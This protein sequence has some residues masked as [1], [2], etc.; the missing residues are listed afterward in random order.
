M[1]ERF[2]TRT[3]KTR[4]VTVLCLNTETGEPFNETVILPKVYRAKDDLT[5]CKAML[6]SETV[7]CCKVVDMEEVAIKYGMS[8]AAFIEVAEVLDDVQDEETEEI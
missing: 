8:E 1:K 5:R 4:R 3:V 7:T 6:D 2:I